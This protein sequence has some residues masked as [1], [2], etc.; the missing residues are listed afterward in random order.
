MRKSVI[1]IVLLSMCNLAEAQYKKLRGRIY[2]GPEFGIVTNVDNAG[3][4]K[5]KVGVSVGG[6]IM[7]TYSRKKYVFAGLNFNQT[8]T[9]KPQQ[10]VSQNF[11][12]TNLNTSRSSLEIPLGLG[13]N[14]TKKQPEGLFW[15]MAIVNNFTLVSKSKVDIIQSGVEAEKVVENDN[16]AVYNIGAKSEL[17]WRFELEK[18]KMC[19]VSIGLKPMFWNAISGSGA[20]TTTWSTYFTLG[21]IL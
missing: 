5:I 19:A 7:H 16:N 17:G 3:F 12:Q 6:E 8:S 11:I 2:A 1:L 13:F 9:T 18:R 4:D 14:F 20:K 10:I 21:Y 15:N